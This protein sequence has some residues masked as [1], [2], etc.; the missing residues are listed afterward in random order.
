MATSELGAVVALNNTTPIQS[1]HAQWEKANA[2]Y[3]VVDEATPATADADPATCVKASWFNDGTGQLHRQAGHL[4]LALLYE[5]PLNMTDAVI[6]AGHIC[7][8]G[9]EIDNLVE[10]F[11]KDA[12]DA[13]DRALASLFAFMADQT[14]F[15]FDGWLGGTL[16]GAKREVA[17]RIGQPELWRHE[18]EAA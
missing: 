12:F 11:R 4:Q 7:S 1:L 18:S 5:V 17:L 10:Q 14:P 3:N 13:L 16:R 9:T 15:E 2:A 6:L 8:H